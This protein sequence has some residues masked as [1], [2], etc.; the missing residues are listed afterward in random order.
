MM[1]AIN[2]LCGFGLVRSYG[3]LLLWL[4]GCYRWGP[5]SGGRGC[6]EPSCRGGGLTG[7]ELSNCEYVSAICYLLSAGTVSRMF[8]RS[9]TPSV[10]RFP[11]GAESNSA[12]TDF[13]QANGS[14]RTFPHVFN[15]ESVM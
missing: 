13:L 10:A 5:P 4:V 7:A 15:G 8:G 11:A 1:R 9:L 2:V 14:Q 3:A 12:P 6:G